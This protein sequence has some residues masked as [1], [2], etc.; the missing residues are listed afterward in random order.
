MSLIWS[1]IEE[2]TSPSTIRVGLILIALFTVSSLAPLLAAGHIEG[3]TIGNLVK[4]QLDSL[5]KAG[6]SGY[7]DLPLRIYLN[8][9]K[10]S[11]LIALLY[12]TVILPV[13]IVIINGLVV[14]FLPIMFDLGSTLRGAGITLSPAD[15]G[16]FYY[17][18]LVPHGMLELTTIVVVAS[19]IAQGFRGGLRGIVSRIVG[20][21]II[22]GVNL[23][24]AAL[25]ETVITPAIMVAVL[26]VIG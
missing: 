1:T 15:A 13:I 25:V 10:V 22:A 24:I 3:T 19:L 21:L 23:L 20:R 7:T 18:G 11:A 4:D 2:V 26:L 16:F 6:E 8:N 14:G 5:K 17:V 12:P 9:V